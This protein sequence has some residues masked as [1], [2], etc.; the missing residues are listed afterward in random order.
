ME[1]SQGINIVLAFCLGVGIGGA[2]VL[3]LVWTGH[4]RCYTLGEYDYLY[5]NFIEEGGEVIEGDRESQS[6]EEREGQQV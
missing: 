6:K 4:L 2:V 1:I 5:K 3:F